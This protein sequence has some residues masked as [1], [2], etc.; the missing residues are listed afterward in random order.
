LIFALDVPSLEAARTLVAEFD[1]TVTFYKVGLE[2]SMVDGYWAFVRELVGAGKKVMVDLKMYDVPETVGRAVA[3]LS[4]YGVT[5]AT[6]H[7]NGDIAKSAIANA[8]GVKILMVTILTSLDVDDLREM[9]YQVASVE[10]LVLQKA[11]LAAA[12]GCDGVIASGREA[13]QL[14]SE[15]ADRLL[16]VTPGV[17][18]AGQ[19]RVQYEDDQKRT[20]TPIQ[21]LANGADYIVVGRPIRDAPNPRQAAEAI[22]RDIA[23]AVR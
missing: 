22:Q 12:A 21:A 5:F 18:Q 16:I 7:G 17:R 11:R 10:E 4:D 20:T 1:N 19:T 3:R 8:N 13:R 2:L 9:G 6:I 14:K 23:A 15:H